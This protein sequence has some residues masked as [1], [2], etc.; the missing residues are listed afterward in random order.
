MYC[1]TVSAFLICHYACTDPVTS[2]QPI[3]INPTCDFILLYDVLHAANVDN[4][5]S[6]SCV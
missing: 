5:K 3:E 4:Y 2:N 6:L 1:S